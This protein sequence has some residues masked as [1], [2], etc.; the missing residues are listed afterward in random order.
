M[1]QQN[2]SANPSDAKKLTTLAQDAIQAYYEGNFEPLLSLITDDCVFI[3]AASDVFY[4]KTDI[5]NS[6][7][8]GDG[9]P[10]FT[11][12]L[13]DFRL[14]ETGTPDQAL[15]MGEYGLHGNFDMPMISAVKQRITIS[16][17]FQDGAWQA[18]C[19]QASNEWNEVEEEETFPLHVSKATFEY[20]QNILQHSASAL[21]DRRRLC[22][23]AGSTTTLIDPD[24]LL[25]AQADG[26]RSILHMTDR[27]LSVNMLLGELENA[28][29]KNF[30]RT[31][32]AYLT[33]AYYVQ[34]ITSRSIQLED[35]TELPLP[36]R[37]YQDIREAL[38]RAQ[39]TR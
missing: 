3:G 7:H 14:I 32:R 17:R 16:C 6:D 8:H 28:L 20:V 2:R 21:A 5:A 22:L 26:K 9:I 30:V 33:N 31:H 19:I 34:G 29:P 37:R 4:C 1:V 25:Y 27:T 38:L 35:G 18:Y 39:A 12:E 23:N 13:A 24:A 10:T 15:I 11:M 36:T